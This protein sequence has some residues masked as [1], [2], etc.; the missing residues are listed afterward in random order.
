MARIT[1]PMDIE[2]LFV[3]RHPFVATPNV[4]Y[5]VKAHR[6]FVDII[7]QG[8]D[9]MAL[10]YT[11]VGLTEA[12]YAAD[13]L[14]GATIISLHSA[15]EKVIHVPDTYIDSY[16]DMG[17]IPHS[18]VVVSVSAGMLPD[19]YATDALEDVLKTAVSDHTGVDA[20]VFVSRAPVLTAIT[21]E[22]YAQNLAIRTAAIK[23]RN[24]TY[25]ENIRL[26]GVVD[27]LTQANQE[28]IELVE[29]LQA[30]IEELEGVSPGG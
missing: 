27:T 22:Q 4:E 18:W 29:S 14:A 28:L 25:S 30:R 13:D 10:V 12:D 11:P 2:G 26:A 5:K 1:P 20:T 3:L 19:V 16:P 8:L 24:T 21:Q 23:N 17:V 7:N 9:P 15:T 6:K